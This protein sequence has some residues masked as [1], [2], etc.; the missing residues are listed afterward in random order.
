LGESIPAP[1]RLGITAS[2]KVGNAVC[3]NRFKRRVREWFRQR[4]HQLPES[5]DLVVI[6]R[7][8]GGQLAFRELDERLC[9]LL[10]LDRGEDLDGSD[11]CGTADESAGALERDQENR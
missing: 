10:E 11:G 8:S 2:R 4:R 1:R 3:R 6:A 9:W 5:I 7:R